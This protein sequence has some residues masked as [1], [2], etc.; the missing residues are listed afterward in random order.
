HAWLFR[1]QVTVNR[2][3]QLLQWAARITLRSRLS[4]THA[5]VGQ[6]PF[7]GTTRG[8]ASADH[9]SLDERAGEYHCPFD[10]GT[11]C[12]FPDFKTGHGGSSRLAHDDRNA[13]SRQLF[14]R[15]VHR[16]FR[17]ETTVLARA[18]TI[19]SRSQWLS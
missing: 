8:T 10:G 5:A 15:L 3:A 14:R 12:A 11:R 4:C 1:T 17:P 16:A 6:N 13:P 19:W 18:G 2:P 7:H 9:W